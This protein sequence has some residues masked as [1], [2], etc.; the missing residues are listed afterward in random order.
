MCHGSATVMIFNFKNNLKHTMHYIY[1][2]LID[3]LQLAILQFPFPDSPTDKASC[4]IYLPCPWRLCFWF[5]YCKLLWAGQCKFWPLLCLP[6][7]MAGD[8]TVL[9]EKSQELIP[10]PCLTSQQWNGPCSSTAPCST[11]ECWS[12]EWREWGACSSILKLCQDS[13]GIKVTHR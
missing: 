13:V 10:P 11:G 12:G 8:A 4:W 2:S 7:Y 3:C 5:Q 1:G 9:A 6:K